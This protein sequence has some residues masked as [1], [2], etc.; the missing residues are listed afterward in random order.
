MLD[1]HEVTGSIPVRPTLIAKGLQKIA[2]LFILSFAHYLPVFGFQNRFSRLNLPK[3]N[4]AQK[5][6]TGLVL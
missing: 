2:V 5:I 1:R 3:K 4:P 6:D